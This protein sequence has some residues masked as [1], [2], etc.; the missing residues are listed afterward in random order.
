[1]RVVIDNNIILDS[2]LPNDEFVGTAKELERRMTRLDIPAYICANSL[3]DIYY[4]L[5]KAH[6]SERAKAEIAKLIDTYEIIPLTEAECAA[7]ISLDMND[8][9][10]A[11]IMACAHKAGVDYIISRDKDF[12]ETNSLI[13]V[14]TPAEF[15]KILLKVLP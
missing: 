9:E 5:R 3:T 11:V 6:K 10:D 1:M 4:F 15:L 8:F 7:A 12:I 14:I 2:M 13:P